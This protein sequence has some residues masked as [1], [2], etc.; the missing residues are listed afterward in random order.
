MAIL[1]SSQGL[2][3]IWQPFEWYGGINRC[4]N[5]VRTFKL[6]TVVD[7]P[8]LARCRVKDFLLTSLVWPENYQP[9]TVLAFLLQITGFFFL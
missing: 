1:I 6:D 8:N 7:D 3:R 9:D 2:T 5:W 4:G